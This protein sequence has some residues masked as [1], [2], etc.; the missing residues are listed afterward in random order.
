[1][2]AEQAPGRTGNPGTEIRLP[3]FG[4]PFP[5]E[6]SPFA[7]SLITGTEQWALETG[8]VPAADA[9]ARLRENG[10]MHAGPRLV[11]GAPPPAAGL[12]CDW[13]VFLIIL[14]DV[15][16]DGPLGSRPGPA[17]DAVTEVISAF[18]GRP[19]APPGR[20]P[21]LPGISAAAADLG[22]RAGELAPGPGW[23]ARF[24][25]HAEEHIRSK[26]QEAE[27]R[28]AGALL[29]V[30][31]YV[32]LRR[33]TSAACAYADLAELACPAPVP[34]PVRESGTWTQMLDAAADV[35]LGIQDICSAAKEAAAGDSLNL[36]AVMARASGGSLQD[37]VDDA[38]RWVRQRSGDLTGLRSRL[39]GPGSPDG[40]A[41]TGQA[42]ALERLLGGH[43]TWNSHGNPRYPQAIPAS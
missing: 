12:A 1:M 3:E 9:A 37:G 19:A 21:R 5:S 20:D 26:A 28:Q 38:Y 15:F 25:R 18:R 39:A 41:M 31:G 16:D 22:R 11:P 33:V 13:T 43:L 30:P 4:L 7:D 6:I 10:I 2:T 24:R 14:D 8:L 42:E 29:D 34:Q 35:W 32:A 40:P 27:L 17:R 36:A 23:L